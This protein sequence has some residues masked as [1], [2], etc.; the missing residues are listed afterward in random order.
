MLQHV[1]ALLVLICLVLIGLADLQRLLRVSAPAQAATK[2][3][4]AK[5]PRPLRP[6]TPEDCPNCRDAMCAPNPTPTAPPR[7][8]PWREVKSRR[9]APKRIHTEAYA[10]PNLECKYRNVTDSRVH[11]LVGYGHY[12]RAEPIQD[13]FCQACRHKLTVRRHTPLYRLTTSAARVALIL[14]T[15][16]EGL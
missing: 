15:L 8:R 5:P 2:E 9:G 11:G 13:L 16:A 1:F 3:T 6:R 12:G 14:T 10:C 4:P 7:L